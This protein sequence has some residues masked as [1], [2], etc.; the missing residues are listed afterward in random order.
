VDPIILVLDLANETLAATIVVLAA[1]ILLYNVTRNLRN[2]IARTSAIVLG[3]VTVAYVADVFVTLG[4]GLSAYETAL[5]F[6]WLGIAYIPAAL[7]HLSDALLA[8]TGLPSRGRRRRVGRLLYAISTL[9]L[10]LALSTDLVINPVTITTTIPQVGAAVGLQAGP[11]FPIYTL[12]LV[13]VVSAAFI[14]ANRARLRCVTRDTRRRMGYLQYA[15][16]TPVVGIYPFSVLLGA[17]TEFSIT[18]LI[19]VNVANFGIVLMLLFLAYPL[20]FFGSSVPDRVVKRELLRFVLRG[21]M[22]AL[23]A[24]GMYVFTKATRQILGLQGEE[25]TPFAIVAVILLWQ[26]GIALA[27]PWLERR[28]VYAGEEFEQLDELADLSERLLTRNDLLQLIDALLASAC[29]YLRVNVAFVAAYQEPHFDMVRALGHDFP[30]NTTLNDYAAYLRSSAAGVDAEN[31]T[32]LVWQQYWLVPLAGKRSSASNSRTG[33]IGLFGIQARNELIDLTDDERKM[34]LSFAARAAEA[35]EDMALQEEI[36]AALEGLLPQ[37]HLTR[38]TSSEIEY[39]PGR[40]AA[41]PAAPVVDRTQ[42]TEQVWAALRHFWGGPGLTN[43]R[44]LE[45]RIVRSALQEN[46]DNPTKALRAV[47]LQ[48]MERLRPDGERKPLSPEWTLFTIL[49]LRFLKG[50]KVRET[51]NRLALSEPDLYRKQRIA[52]DAVAETLWGMEY[53]GDLRG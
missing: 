39:R 7:F 2:R 28:L 12:V 35:L 1:S 52:I 21:P 48:A 10:I 19:L 8:T 14:N 15:M 38:R 49:E 3:C 4:P 23:L 11:V 41:A 30:T 40:N 47:L 24:L 51:A 36:Y 9:F 34:M 37:I 31:G 25:F 33:L 13:I 53:D 44:L 45:L 22:T 16:L 27:L 26:W 50:M 5:R 32:I 20:S 17:G 6:Q 42:F 18:G 29:D 43:S 46:D